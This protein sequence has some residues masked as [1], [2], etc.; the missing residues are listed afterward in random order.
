MGEP[1]PVQRTKTVQQALMIVIPHG[2]PP[3][4]QMHVKAP[5]GNTCLVQVPPGM[6]PGQQLQV[7]VP[8]TVTETVYQQAYQRSLV[9]VLV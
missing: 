3:N 4:G 7:S 8:T 9:R 5:S 2:L 6:G 1:G